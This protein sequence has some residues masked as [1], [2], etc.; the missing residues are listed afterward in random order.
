MRRNLIFGSVSSRSSSQLRASDRKN[1][2]TPMLSPAC[3]SKS[4]GTSWTPWMSATIQ[5][6]LL[7][8]WK[9]FCSG[10]L[11]K[12][13]GQSYF[14]LLRLP[15]DMQGLKPSIL[16]GKLKQHL[17][18]GVSPDTDLF[19]AM[20]LIRLPPSM[21]EA[22]G[23]G[24]HKTAADTVRAADALWDAWGGHDPTVAAA[25]THRSRSPAP[26]SGKT[27]D[28]RNGNARLPALLFTLSR[29]LPM[30]CASFTT[31]TPTEHTGILHPVFFRKTKVPPSLFWFGGH[32]STRHCHGDAF[33]SQCGIDF[34]YR[35]ID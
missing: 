20:F 2:N 18:P 30:A 28:K 16:M 29:T 32:S 12:A 5:I 24:N 25:T 15:M 19:M 14:E 22:V 7:I 26:T 6:I 34:P 23:A 21:R 27:T 35:W 17:P 9:L 3:P 4:S 10:I 1:S 11:E 8:F 33:P 31:I 13:S